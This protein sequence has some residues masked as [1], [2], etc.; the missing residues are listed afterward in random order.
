MTSLF[1]PVGPE[2][3]AKLRTAYTDAAIAYF[4]RV[5]PLP[6]G[7]RW[8]AHPY[9]IGMCAWECT[10]CMRIEHRA[11]VTPHCYCTVK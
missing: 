1:D 11:N 9:I 3:E 5:S 2:E 4:R 7:F 10:N 6:D 8:V